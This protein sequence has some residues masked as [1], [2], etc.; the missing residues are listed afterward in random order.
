[1]DTLLGALAD[2]DRGRLTGILDRGVAGTAVIPGKHGGPARAETT[3]FVA[4]P[5]HPGEL[6]RLLADAGRSAS[7]SRTCASTT[8][9]AAST[10]WSSSPSATG[11]VDHLLSSL[12]D[13]GWT[14]H[15]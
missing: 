9:R 4:V 5:D 10:A 15:R 7:T 2:G 11:Q 1:M 6:A 14:T 13:R 8:T 12:E 3:L